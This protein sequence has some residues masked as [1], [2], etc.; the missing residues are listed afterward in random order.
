M[1]PQL[2]RSVPFL[3][4][5]GHIVPYIPKIVVTGP[6]VIREI[7]VRGKRHGTGDVSRPGTGVGGDVT[8][9]AMDFGWLHW[10]DFDITLYG[11]PAQAP[12]RPDAPGDPA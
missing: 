7:P 12:V 11:T 8:T 10:K 1:V 4:K 2:R 5:N 3:V 6:P 9:V